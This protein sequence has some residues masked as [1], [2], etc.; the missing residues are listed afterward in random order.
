MNSYIE[1]LILFHWKKKLFFY[2]RFV[3]F[4]ADKPL[5][6]RG[7]IS[8]D[9]WKIAVTKV[10]TITFYHIICIISIIICCCNVWWQ[11]KKEVK[12]RQNLGEES[13]QRKQNILQ[14]YTPKHPQI[15]QLQVWKK[16]EKHLPKKILFV[17][18]KYKLKMCFAGTK[19]EI[20]KL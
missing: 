2:K 4:F 17:K 8:E 11:V 5:L 7:C 19:R 1:M 3:F 9:Q 6:E 18:K 14:N 10:A 15:N 20:D 13:L 12:R 16:C